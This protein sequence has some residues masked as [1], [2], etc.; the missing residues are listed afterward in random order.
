MDR[1]LV[2]RACEL[3]RFGI[4]GREAAAMAMRERGEDPAEHY[5]RRE[6]NLR[7]MTHKASKIDGTAAK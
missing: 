2:D 4:L 6:T 3:M 7:W 5:R 1:A